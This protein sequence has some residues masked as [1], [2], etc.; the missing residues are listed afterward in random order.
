MPT[1]VGRRK[2]MR[3]KEVEWERKNNQASVYLF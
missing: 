2:R 3:E 1:K